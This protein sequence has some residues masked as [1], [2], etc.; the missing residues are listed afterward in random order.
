M[1]LN[2]F[3]DPHTTLS[4]WSALALN[5]GL[6][7]LPIVTDFAPN[8]GCLDLIRASTQKLQAGIVQYNR[9]RVD[10]GISGTKY[11]SRPALNQPRHK[12]T[13]PS[14]QTTSDPATT[15]LCLIY[16]RYQRTVLFWKPERYKLF[17]YETDKCAL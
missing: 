10:A 4:A 6:P 13:P 5:R 15:T 16:N 14:I 17:Q 1:A 2:R 7:W 12:N 3:I 9:F 11:H 8:F